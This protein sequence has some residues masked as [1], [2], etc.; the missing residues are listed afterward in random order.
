MQS[1]N[2]MQ[3]G[4]LV[5]QTIVSRMI[6]KTGFYQSSGG[7]GYR[8]QLQDALGMKW[9]DTLIFDKKSNGYFDSEYHYD[10]DRGFE[11]EILQLGSQIG[12]YL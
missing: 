7:Y 1:F 3:N 10:Q 6:A 9:V 11:R 5:Y 8:D 2:A 4:Y 12:K